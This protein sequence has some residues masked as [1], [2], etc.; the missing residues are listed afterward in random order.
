MINATSALTKK[1]V[2]VDR[3]KPSADDEEGVLL[4][5]KTPLSTDVPILSGSN[6][7]SDIAQTLWGLS[8]NTTSMEEE[9][10]DVVFDLALRR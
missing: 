2:D 5:Q 9:E 6:R 10:Q 8:G 1:V 7:T 4:L 3:F